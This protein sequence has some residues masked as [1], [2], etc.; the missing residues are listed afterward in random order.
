VTRRPEASA[1]PDPRLLVVRPPLL[2]LH[3]RLL[4]AERSD[5]E[6]FQGRLTSAEFLQIATG[7]LRMAWLSPLSELIV[8]IDEALEERP[9]LADGVPPADVA[10]LVERL[11]GLVAPP[12][13]GTAFGRR[14]LGMLQVHPAVVMAHS[15]LVQA[16]AAAPA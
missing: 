10:A 6:R 8:A 7:G 3:R 15:A 4:E 16:L 2:E 1:G 14:Y 11:R 5:M 9:D 13:G 12:D